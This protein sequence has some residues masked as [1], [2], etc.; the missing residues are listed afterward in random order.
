MA[1]ETLF[2][3]TAHSNGKATIHA[4]AIP[5]PTSFAKPEMT[6]TSAESFAPTTEATIANVVTI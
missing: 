6:T 4:L 3:G 5:S 2:Q 1:T